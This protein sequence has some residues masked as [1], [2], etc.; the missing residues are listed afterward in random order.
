MIIINDFFV[1]NKEAV[2]NE[3]EMIKEATNG[4][5][6]SATRFM[7]QRSFKR[8]DR[9]DNIYIYPPFI[10]HIV[11]FFIV[12][13]SKDK[14]IL[15]YE[16]EPQFEKRFLLNLSRKNIFVSMYREPFKEY[17]EHIK[18]YKK[19]KAVFVEME[20][21][22]DIL[23]SLGINKELIH[24]SYTPSRY[25]IC[26]NKKQFNPKKVNLLFASWNNK[27]GNPLY[28][29]GLV[30]I[31]ELLQKN[32]NF[33]LTVILRD[34]DVKEFKNIITKKNLNDRVK[35]LNVTPKEL[36]EEYDNTDFTIYTIQKKLT[37][38]VPN[39]LIDSLSRGK[40]VI[41]TDIFGFHRIVEYNNLGI[42]LK[43]GSKA[44]KLNVSKEKYDKMSLNAT[45]IS[46]MYSKKK[47]VQTFM[48]VF[49]SIQ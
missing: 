28:E 3:M 39:S 1:R 18:K 10:Y 12:L 37:K 15:I 7:N 41:M 14:N 23:I 38:D 13:F 16:E 26:F 19:L 2:S 32:S 31:L 17:A 4:K 46:K 47:Y 34:N 49:R 36:L 30:Y 9:N 24:V 35:L 42:V 20:A 43:P 11:L 40:P 5:I 21:H 25:S 22:K 48:S 8:K 27:E 45:M 44:K 29:R 6:I 33:Y